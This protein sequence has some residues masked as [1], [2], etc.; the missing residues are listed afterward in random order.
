MI[1]CL[2][3]LWYIRAAEDLYFTNPCYKSEDEAMQ[4]INGN[5]ALATHSPVSVT[6]SVNYNEEEMNARAMK[7]VQEN[8]S[9]S[10]FE[11]WTLI[12]YYWSFIDEF[13]QGGIDG[14]VVLSSLGE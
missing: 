10:I 4:V 5:I 13:H 9:D 12:D 2:A 1:T 7:W 8:F 11:K 3:T 6:Y 14:F